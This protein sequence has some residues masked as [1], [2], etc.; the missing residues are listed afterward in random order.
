MIDFPKQESLIFYNGKIITMEDSN[1]TTSAVFVQDGIIQAIGPQ[2]EILSRKTNKT[3]IIDL[4]GRTLLPGFIDPHTHLATSTFLHTMVDLSGFTNDTPEQLW[5]RLQQH[6]SITPPGYWI[7][8]KGLDP[9]LVKGLEAPHISFLDSIAPQNPVIILAQS[10]HSYWGNSLAFEKV[11]IDKNTTDPSTSSFYEKDTNGNLTGFIAEQEAF[12]PF[13]HAF[14]KIFTS[15]LMIRTT[16]HVLEDYAKRGNTTIVSTGLSIQDGKPL[17]LYEH[18]SAAK[19][20][21]LN[22]LLVALS[23]LPPRSSTVRHFI[24]HRHDRVHLLPE[25]PQNGDDHYR[26]LGVKHW[27]D[28]SPYTGS[29]FL[30]EPY[31]VSELTEKGLLIPEGGHGERLVEKSALI[32]FIEKYQNEGW[33]IAVHTQ[34]DAAINETIE[35][36]EKV[37]IN[38]D[39]SNF[40]HRLEHCL[41]LPDDAIKKLAKLNITP[42]IHINHILYY[43]EALKND[44]IGE[45]RANKILPLNSIHQNGLKFSLHADQP[46]FESHPL[47][48]IQTAV[49][50]KTKKGEILGE[51]EKLNIM[52]ALKAMTIHAAWQIKMENKI[53]SIKVGK[54]ADL[55]IL[56]KNP[57]EVPYEELENIQVLDAFVSGNEVF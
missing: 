19:P 35:A 51:N 45:E 18:L 27:Y 36:F 4:Q 2:E 9:I 32:D 56:D 11:G 13:I 7:I 50:R 20:K 49:E 17:Q 47:R 31:K 53:G 1:P 34:G 46:M 43:G 52:E 33:Q 55:I 25:S 54:Y 22:Q 37:N 38:N 48:L 24:Y 10:L 12:Q 26:V 6:V 42:S 41:L 28:G 5:S 29:M 16:I 23:F 8:C 3:K 57:L 15:D 30:N 44:I 14:E 40:R 21:L 39:I